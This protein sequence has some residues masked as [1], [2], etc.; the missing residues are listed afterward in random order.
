MGCYPTPVRDRTENQ[1]PDRHQSRHRRGVNSMG[2][3]K[4]FFK[5]VISPAQA[6]FTTILPM[7]FPSKSPMNAPSAWSSPSTT[8]SLFFSLPDCK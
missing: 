3:P 4:R 2:L 7:F 1:W 6:S 8:V 5:V